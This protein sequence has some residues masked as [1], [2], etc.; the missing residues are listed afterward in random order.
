M[1]KNI[2]I[3]VF[4][5]LFILNIKI[6]MS[7]VKYASCLFFEKIFIS[8]F[9]FMILC[10]VLIYFDY[11]NFIKNSFPGKIIS[12]LFN[13]DSNS[14]SILIFSIFT[15]QPN[16]SIYI[17][18]MLDN[19][20]IDI[21]SANKLLCFTYFPSISFVIGTIGIFMFNSFKIGFLLYLNCILNNILI[22]LFLRNEYISSIDKDNNLKNDSFLNML[23]TSIIK[24][25]NNLYI[26]LGNIIIFTI[27]INL[28]SHFFNFDEFIIGVISIFLELT[29]GIN[30][31]ALSNIN[32]ICKLGLISFGL[33]FSG[34]SILFQSF[35]ILS[36]YKINIKKILVI[37]LIFS[38]ISSIIFML[39][40]PIFLQIL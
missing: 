12:K 36:D 38:I 39:G 19:K 27:I 13:I 4:L 21:N 18:N 16:N 2:F 34:L 1:K 40:F 28:I 30:N 31:I 23:K 3:S 20:C 35:S 10:D 7:S 8:S 26:I 17:R 11:H 29:N 32:L 33:N 6:V 37:K 9:P 15:S 14:S 5:V 22:G 25:F 24:S